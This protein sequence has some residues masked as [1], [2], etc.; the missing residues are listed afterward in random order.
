MPVAWLSLEPEDNEPVRFLTYLIAALQ[1]LDPHLGTA[2]LALLHT[3]QTAPPERVLTLLA[4]DI[5]E[6]SAGDFAFVLDDYH[7]IEAGSIHRGMGFLLEHLPPQMH[8]I[9]ATRTDPP[10]PLVRLR[11]R[12]QLKEVRAADLRF[13]T[14]EASTFLQAVMRLDLSTQE[15]ALLQNRTEGW[16]AGLQ[17]AALS[18]RGRTDV[19]AFL[20]AFTGSH[21]F[22]LD[23]L[24]EEVLARQ[25]SSVQTFLLH[26]SVLDRLRGPLCEAVT[27]QGEGQAMLE[28]FDQANLFVVSLD[29]ERGWY[30][31]HHLFADVLKSRLQQAE[32]LL[33]P[34][35]HRR[36][37]RWYEQHGLLVAGILGLIG[38]VCLFVSLI[39]LTVVEYTYVVIVPITALQLPPPL[40]FQVP[41]PL[42]LLLSMVLFG[43]ATIRAGVLPRAVGI[44]FFVNPVVMVIGFVVPPLLIP[45]FVLSN[46]AVFVG[47]IELIRSK[48]VLVQ[49]AASAS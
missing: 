4:N 38:F 34:E 20:A 16:I 21:R 7:V 18:L 31:Y 5:L 26:T 8:L 13:A 27:G 41:F 36:A 10:L 17:L 44:A 35:L 42:F 25:D 6:S 49:G 45:A 22:V 28:A 15:I 30:R 12:G 33:V 11:A 48:A 46:L 2:A 29:D 3:P 9:I 19:S 39:A 24:S 14:E 40:P 43:I 37:S 47:G 1:T 32:P 23:Y